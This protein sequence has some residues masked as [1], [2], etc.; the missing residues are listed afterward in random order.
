MVAGVRTGAPFIQDGV[1]GVYVNRL[2]PGAKCVKTD[3]DA[4]ALAAF[5]TAIHRSQTL[6][7]GWV[8]SETATRFASD[9]IGNTVILTV[10]Q[11][12]EP[13][14]NTANGPS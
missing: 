14:L 13:W 2:P 10:Q 7:R 12:R 11:V 4:T 1:T 3:A 8:H 9:R 5:Q 6:P